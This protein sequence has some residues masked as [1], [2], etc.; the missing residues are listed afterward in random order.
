MPTFGWLLCPSIKQR[1]SRAKGPPISLFFSLINIPPQTTGNRP[2]HTFRPGLASSPTHSFT[3]TPSSIWLLFILIK[4]RPPKAKAAPLSLLFHAC[5]FASPS[6]QTNDSKRNL[7][8]LRPAH[9][10]GERRRHDLGDATALPMEREWAKPLEGRVARLIL[11][12]VVSVCVVFCVLCSN[13]R[14]D[15]CTFFLVVII[16]SFVIIGV[17]ILTWQTVICYLRCISTIGQTTVPFFPVKNVSNC[18]L[19]PPKKI[20]GQTT[21]PFFPVVFFSGC[22][23]HNW[24]SCQNTNTNYNPKKLQPE[25]KVQLSGRLCFSNH[26][27]KITTGK[28]RYIQ[29]SHL[30]HLQH[31]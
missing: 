3:S 30:N 10:I 20:A 27:K 22:K 2:P 19:N 16:S 18:N 5:Y 8:R 11:L 23:Y 4:W 1:L 24:C 25:K 13:Q 28:K 26:R 21:V 6:K 12:V 31:T 15:D 7:D 14:P 29:S 17:R 9:G